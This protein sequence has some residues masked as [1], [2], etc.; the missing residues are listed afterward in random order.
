MSSTTLTAKV[1]FTFTV[2]AASGIAQLQQTEDGV[3]NLTFQIGELVNIT[4]NVK[5]ATSG[6]GSSIRGLLLNLRMFSF[7]IRT[8]RREFGNTNP[9]IEKISANLITLAAVTTGVAAA[10]TMIKGAIDAFWASTTYVVLALQTIIFALGA[11]QVIAIGLALIALPTVIKGIQNFTSGITQLKREAKDVAS[12]ISMMEAA[13]KQLSLT[14]ERFNIGL[15]QTSLSIMLLQRAIDLQQTGTEQLQAQM[16]TLN[17]ELRNQEI[18]Q[19]GLNLVQSQRNLILKEARD[20][21]ADILRQEEAIRRAGHEP[22]GV[23]MM[24]TQQNLLQYLR[25]TGWEPGDD[26]NRRH[27]LDYIQREQNRGGVRRGGGGFTGGVIINIPNA[28]F[29]NIEDLAGALT[30]AA[31]TARDIIYNQ[32]ADPG[33]QR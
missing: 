27:M 21:N 16:E 20:L 9:I 12:D 24:R 10:F 19:A 28:I 32:Y 23:G 1:K 6:Y 3:V 5:G 7:A 30:G 31:M 22:G 14:Q 18:N 29:Q 2:D 17:A 26:I 4:N 15:S 25:A 13:I 11:L 8:L 33:G